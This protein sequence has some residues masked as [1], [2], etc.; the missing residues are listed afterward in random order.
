MSV[1]LSVFTVIL[2]AI[3]MALSLAHALEWPGK[4]R[5]DREQY[6]I[7]Q[8]IYYPGFTI[9]G[10]A[11][12]IGIIATAALLAI[13]AYGTPQFWL[14]GGAL[15]LL[16]AMHAIYWLVTHPVNRFWLRDET[17]TPS[18][19]RF[20][21]TGTDGGAPPQRDWTELRDQWEGSHMLRAVAA[22]LGLILLVTA[23]AL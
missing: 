8:P 4:M 2:V 18:A 17:L 3:T 23:V 1:A 9:G 11:E 19:S 22:M 13:T 12:G 10:F 6:L 7:V 14:T 5:L 21:G 15:L 20:F 16:I